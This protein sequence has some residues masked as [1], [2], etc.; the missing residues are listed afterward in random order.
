MAE[1]LGR[2]GLVLK[3]LYDCKNAEWEVSDFTPH[4]SH[5]AFQHT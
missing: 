5:S 4:I 3:I 1:L 2:G